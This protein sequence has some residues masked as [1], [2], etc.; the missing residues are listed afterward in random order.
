MYKHFGFNSSAAKILTQTCFH[1]VL[2]MKSPLKVFDHVTLSL[3]PSRDHVT[4]IKRTEIV[5]K[6][7][8]ALAER[9]LSS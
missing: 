3:H 5:P 7:K 2:Y 9:R 8:D 6:A 1:L 4:S